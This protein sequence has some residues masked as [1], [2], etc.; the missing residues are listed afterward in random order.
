MLGLTV[1]D[2][3]WTAA[4]G[5]AIRIP[6]RRPIAFTVDTATDAG[7]VTK[8]IATTATLMRLVD[9]GRV[10][11]DQDVEGILGIGLDRSITITDL[12]E[13]QAGL[14]EW[15]PLYLEVSD[16]DAALP[17]IAGLPPRYPRRPAGT[18]RI[19]ASCCSVLSSRR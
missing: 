17:L 7:S 11:L 10:R 5:D 9:A 1:G 12:L 19:W 8:I 15:R 6:G 4:W 18:T 2:R 3:T 13:H 14:A 16:P